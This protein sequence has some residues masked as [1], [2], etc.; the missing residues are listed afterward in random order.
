[1]KIAVL[2]SGK[3]RQLDLNKELMKDFFKGHEVDYFCHAWF[4]KTNNTNEKSWQDSFKIDSEIPEKILDIYK[5]KNWLIE[6]QR[7][8]ELSR[9]YNYNT[10]HPQPFFIVF[11]H[12]YSLK[13]AN[14]LRLAYEKETG[15]KYDLVVKLRYDLFIGN[16]IKWETYDL[17]NL[18]LIDN[19]NVWTDFHDDVSF[20][21]AFAF[22]SPENMTTYC[23]VFDDMDKNYMENQLRFSCE[24]F[25]SYHLI[26]NNVNVVPLNFSRCFVIRDHS[27]L[28]FTV[29]FKV[30]TDKI[31][32]LIAHI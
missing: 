28:D 7:L 18:Y 20:N 29:G 22:S 6:T 14:L 16:K 11:S 17:N 3:P 2:L 12:F 25:L 5:P 26:S 23:N 19:C 32:D 9:N 1:M 24:S 10:G 15:V 27:C 13:T 4:N 31:K 30:S 21:D 8:F